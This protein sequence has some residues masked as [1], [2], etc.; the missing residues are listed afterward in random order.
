MKHGFFISITGSMEIIIP[1]ITSIY[2]GPAKELNM[3]IMSFNANVSETLSN[4]TIVKQLILMIP[5]PLDLD[6]T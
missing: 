2:S 6:T 5:K 4:T 1:H 3:R